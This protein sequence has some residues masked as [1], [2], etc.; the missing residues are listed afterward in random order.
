MMETHH[1]YNQR[2]KK[3]NTYFKSIENINAGTDGPF[4]TVSD[5]KTSSVTLNKLAMRASEYT[6]QL[7]D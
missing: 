6:L 4:C 3:E 5:D 1:L 7:S 2:K